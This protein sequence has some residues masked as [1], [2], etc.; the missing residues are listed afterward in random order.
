MRYFLGLILTSLSL[1]LYADDIKCYSNG[2]KI[3]AGEGKEFSYDQGIFVFK[4]TKS[5]KIIFIAG[6]CIVKVKV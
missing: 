1:N 2:R 4:D 6:D 5:D 3:Y